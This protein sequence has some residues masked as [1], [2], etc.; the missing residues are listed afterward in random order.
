[1][2]KA[3]ALVVLIP[4]FSQPAIGREVVNSAGFATSVAD[5]DWCGANVEVEVRGADAAAFVNAHDRLVGAIALTAWNLKADCAAMQKINVRG[6]AGEDLVYHG[7]ALESSS[8]MAQ[9]LA[10][11]PPP[12][13]EVSPPKA[14]PPSPVASTPPPSAAP[15]PPVAPPPPTRVASPPSRP[16]PPPTASPPPPQRQRRLQPRPA[17]RQKPEEIRFTVTRPRASAEV[18]ISKA[19]CTEHYGSPDVHITSTDEALFTEGN[20]E[21]EGLLREIGGR[22]AE[23]C[24]PNKRFTARGYLDYQDGLPTEYSFFTHVENSRT[25]WNLDLPRYNTRYLNGVYQMRRD[26]EGP[27]LGVEPLVYSDFIQRIYDGHFDQIRVRFMEKDL[28][29]GFFTVYSQHCAQYLPANAKNYTIT[30]ELLTHT[31]YWYGTKTFYY[32]EVPYLEVKIPPQYF[33]LFVYRQNHVDVGNILG[34]LLNP[35]RAREFKAIWGDNAALLDKNGCQS[36][37]VWRWIENLQAYLLNSPPKHVTPRS[38]RLTGAEKLAWRKMRAENEIHFEQ[39]LVQPPLDEI[40]WYTLHRAQGNWCTDTMVMDMLYVPEQYD[41]LK[42]QL[43][44]REGRENFIEIG[45]RHCS[46]SSKLTLNVYSL[47]S[48]KREVQ[49]HYKYRYDDTKK[50]GTLVLVGQ[51]P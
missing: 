41:G 38:R 36:K 12:P 24:P 27:V 33:D 9:A 35:S 8:W 23:L 34:L 4:L 20:T 37:K 26:Y 22:I 39:T 19:N 45:E 14:S 51:N 50:A 10:S 18:N 25:G 44:T 32:E 17:P 47:D 48:K 40:G 29:Q 43:T 30:Q 13:P 11:P 16:T 31:E 46:N 21:M 15:P 49:Y 1:M 3:L 6:F 5:S 2:N 42:W 7:E 28:Y